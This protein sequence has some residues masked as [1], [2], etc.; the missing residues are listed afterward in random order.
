MNFLAFQWISAAVAISGW[1]LL[2]FD[3]LIGLSVALTGSIMWMYIGVR[4]K[5]KPL[6]ALQLAFAVIQ[7]VNIA[8]ILMK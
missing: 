7:I 1:A 8:R 5:N 4:T 2:T 3:L 6:A